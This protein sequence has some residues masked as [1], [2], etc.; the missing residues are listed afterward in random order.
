L[1]Q[2]A[3]TLE[4]LHFG[5]TRTL[6]T[7]N[8][9]S[10]GFITP[11]HKP[12]SSYLLLDVRNEIIRIWGPSRL[13]AERNQLRQNREFIKI[14]TVRNSAPARPLPPVNSLRVSRGSKPKESA[15]GRDGIASASDVG[16]S[17]NWIT[18]RN[19]GKGSGFMDLGPE[20]LPNPNQ[21]ETQQ[22]VRSPIRPK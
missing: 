15:R 16:N 20:K 8:S 13:R 10:R 21:S 9:R 7:V 2:M 6:R 19:P 22:T 4:I 12:A 14:R 11:H 5:R 17:G 18:G 1:P 3:D